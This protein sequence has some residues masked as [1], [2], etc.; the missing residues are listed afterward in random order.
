[1][2]ARYKADRAPRGNAP[3]RPRAVHPR[4]QAAPQ[5]RVLPARVQPPEPEPPAP[6]YIPPESEDPEPLTSRLPHD[7]CAYDA[8]NP[9]VRL[10]SA[11]E[12]NPLT[13]IIKPPRKGMGFWRGLVRLL[14][15]PFRL[16]IFLTRHLPKIICWPV[17]L[18]FIGIFVGTLAAFIV[19]VLVAIKANRYDI[20]EIMRMPERTI[21]L[22]RKGHE[23]GTLHGENRRRIS[24]LRDE[25]PEYFLD[26]LI[27]QEDR[28][29]W[30]HG[31][32]DARGVLRAVAQVYSHGRATQGAS[33]LTMQL[34][35]NT[36]GHLVR[37]MEAKLTEV[38][39]AY[40]IE[41]TYDKETILTCYIN[42]VFWG[43]TFL[44]LKQAAYGYFNKSPRELTIGEAAMLAGIVCSPNKFS[45]YRSLSSA[46][47]QRDKVLKLLHDFGKI[48]RSE[49]EAAV[50]EPIQVCKPPRRGVDNYSLDLIR[51]EVDH[52]L[53][54]LE[55][56]QQRVREDAMYAGGLVVRTTMDVDLQD[57]VM[58]QLDEGLVELLESRRGYRHQTRAQYLA[59]IEG[60]PVDEAQKIR[61]AYVQAACVMVDNA[62]GALLAVVGGRDSVESPLNRAVQSR[63]QVGSI[64][65]PIVYTTFFERGGSPSTMISDGRIQPGEITGA[66]R[67]RPGNSDGRFTGMHPASWGL[68]KSRNT[69]SVRVGNRA[70]LENVAAKALLSGFSD[71]GRPKGPTIY[72]G[73]WEASPLEVAGAY[74]AFA[75]G[76]VRPTPYIIESITDA[77]GRVVWLNPSSSQRIYSARS[78]NATSSVLQQIT[79]P[80]GTAGSVKKLG[81]TA[82]C[83]GKTGTT[84]AFKNAWFCGFTSDITAAVWV[85]FDRQRT[86][87]DRAYGGT[88]ALP[89]W[90]RAMNAASKLGYAMGDIRT[91]PART[92]TSGIKL[93]R[94]SG[95][96]AHAGC[97]LDGTSYVEP[98][99]DHNKNWQYCPVHDMLAEDPDAAPEELTA[100]DPD[101][102]P[103][104]LIAEDP[105]E[106]PDIDE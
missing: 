31:G 21:V 94:T 56:D 27:L 64:F 73:T 96:L 60:L 103:G 78:A 90:V 37:D 70:G 1:M 106:M 66:G 72:L 7:F 85:G 97:D 83:G 58:E 43:H 101:A 67:W 57:A 52:I 53:R 91:T 28:S 51:R 84:N 79:K 48:T 16:I 44:G 46:T 26:A 32:V 10:P 69:M 104:E 15:L 38:A 30:K 95:M 11:E 74:T 35:K 8:Y 25:V 55:T 59:S 50:A 3:S 54:V 105:D 6:A 34:A 18:L 68:L 4:G 61:P 88:I 9:S 23:I 89:L 76:G 17:R 71:K 100:E 81:F 2:C 39:L 92:R 82:P 93:C 19:A 87:A 80:G 5:P 47:V 22:D 62:T 33:T 20:S 98:M 36:Y 13:E 49:Y 40:R 65:K 77:A 14:L 75:N 45:P 29:F 12:E 102:M 41:S 24:N 99:A 86:I 63:R 42:R